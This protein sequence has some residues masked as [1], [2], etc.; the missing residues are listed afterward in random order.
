MT[1]S[2]FLKRVISSKTFSYVLILLLIFGLVSLGREITYRLSLKKELVRKEVRIQTLEAENQELIDE[3]LKRKTEY[4]KEKQA[5]L[6]FGLSKP[7][8]E[9]VVILED[10]DERE[11]SGVNN[12]YFGKKNSNIKLW[13]EYFFK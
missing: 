4:Y 11:S 6:K 12:N 9:V 8:E 7:G 5:R 13:V 1:K 3:L 2:S 10:D